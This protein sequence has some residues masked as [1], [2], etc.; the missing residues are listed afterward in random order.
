M[1]RSIVESSLRFRPLVIAIAAIIIGVGVARLD[2]MPVDIFP[3]ILP[4]TVH[5]QTEALGLSAVEVEQLITVPIEADLLAGTPWV[6]VMRSESVPG[7]SSIEMIFKPGTDPMDARQVVQERLTQAHALPNVSKPPHMLE[8]ASSTNRIMLIGLSS[9]KQS[10]IE[11]SVLAR[12]TIR[13]RLMGVQGVANV[14]IWGQRERQLQ[15]LVDPERLRDH[16]VSL[17]NVLKTAGNA[18]WYSPLSFLESSVAGTGGF[19]ET[20]NQRIGVRHVL[21]IQVAAD[22]AKLPVEGSH[23]R[24]DQVATVVEDHQPL[25]GDAMSDKG[26]GLLLVV[27]KLPGV[28]T[29]QVTDEILEALESL[30]PG[31]GGIEFDPQVYQP[32]NY[33]RT[34][35]SN[36]STALLIAFVLVVV[37]LLALTASWR[38]AVI[39]A[40]AIPV[41][42]LAATLVM[43]LSGTTINVMVLAGLVIA[44]GALIDDGIMD[45]DNFL[46]R[47]RRAGGKS[48]LANLVEASAE[49]RSPLFFATAIVLLIAV[50]LVFMA[51]IPGAFVKP[52]AAAYVLAVLASFVVA[53]TLTPAL[54]LL[55]MQK[56]PLSRQEP[57]LAAWM[58][59]RYDGMPASAV[60]APRAAFVIGIALLVLAAVL[61]PQVRFTTAPTFKEPDLLVQWDAVPGTSRQAMNRVI[62]RVSREL[63]GVPGVRDVG[64]HVGRAILADQVVGINSSELWVNL[65]PK[66]D[67]DATIAAVEEIVAGY[68]GIDGD[69]MT[70]LRS[71]FGE[72]LAG[73][74]EPVVVRVYGQELQQLRQQAE[75]VRQVLA[76]VSGVVDPHIEAETEEPVVEIKVDLEAATNHGVKPGDVRRAAATLLAGIEV[77]NLFE[78]QKI[79]EV[80]VWGEPQVRHSVAGIENLLIDK[81]EGGHVRLGDV[82]SVVVTPA[83][84]VIRR[85]N[86]ARRLD[87]VA[88][89]NG[90]DL[91]AV[92]ADI[93]T[94]LGETQFP[95]EYRAELIGDYAARMAARGRVIWVTAGIV[96]GILLILQAAFGSWSLATVVVVTLPIAVAGGVVAAAITGTTLSLGSIGG[97]LTLVGLAVRHAIL[98][99][100]RYKDLRHD[101]GAEFGPELVRRGTGERAAPILIA[102]VVTAVAVVPFALFGSRPGHEILGPMAIVIL[103][104]LV[105]TTLYTLCIVPALYA[106]FGAGAMPDTLEEEQLGVAV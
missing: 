56:T 99:V 48:T 66:A 2:D 75:R 55:L 81:P 71:R 90:R 32:A 76:G 68:P 94:K 34:V 39:A 47:L 83:P 100:N 4:V 44:L 15:V 70:Y 18:L 86:V 19:I 35:V 11:M 89:I 82:A 95:L 7:L 30:K 29:L 54:G 88:G 37:A 98:M 73:V 101:D 24:L 14:S 80:V 6:E 84:D 31:L 3:E 106:K 58:R 61:V 17:I 26:P 16:N 9:A 69:V 62:D 97:F 46:R 78:E 33:I 104:G 96:A 1:M 51:G 41:S 65:D 91:D 27:E 23:L 87:V 36:V 50:P 21:P 59:R 12:W 8:P 77:G 28:N 52:M 102:V 22:L 63:R 93:R 13:P 60:T 38:T 105:T 42:L 25:I 67:Y 92:S 57:P 43:Y 5:V 20:P 10:L 72:A 45:A 40:V 64:A 53:C 103:G 49:I 79:F 74:D 85:E